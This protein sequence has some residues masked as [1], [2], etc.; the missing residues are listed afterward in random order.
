MT[1]LL[2]GILWLA[3]AFAEGIGIGLGIVGGAHG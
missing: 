3:H 2:T 1:A